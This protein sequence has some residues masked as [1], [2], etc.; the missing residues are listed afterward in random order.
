ML[1]IKRLAPVLL[2]AFLAIPFAKLPVWAGDNLVL[3]TSQAAQNAND[4]VSWAQLGGDATV[5]SSST[6]NANTLNGLTVTGTLAGPNSLTAVACPASPS[7]SWNSGFDGGDEVLW[8]ADAGNSG[9]GPLTVSFSQGVTGVGA[10]VQADAPGQ[11]TVQIQAFNQSG[12]LIHAPFT[13]LSDDHGDPTYIG[14]TDTFGANITAV[15]FSLV[16][17]CLGD[18]K[19]FATD[20]LYVNTVPASPTPTATATPTPTAIPTPAPTPAPLPAGPPTITL[21]PKSLAF[22]AV[23]YAFAGSGSKIKRLTITNPSKYKTAAI[24][25]S[26]V[27]TAGFSADPACNN[28][29]LAAGGKLKCNITYTPIGL[30]AVSGTLTINDNV[31]GGSQTVGVSGTGNQGKLTATPGTLSFGKITVNTSAAK[32]VTLRNRSAS[33]FTISSI[34]DANPAF[35][36]SQNCVGPIVAGG[37]CP[38]TVT[39][40]PTSTDKTTDT[41]SIIDAPDGITRNVNLTGSG[42]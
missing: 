26:I 6:F 38:I 4:S 7:C 29:T 17:P 41:L 35:V 16:Q 14:I 3:V 1:K 27:G 31:G 19:D 5:L 2:A 32:T 21:S 30:G 37:S 40:A 36:A 15:T 18:C 34:G 22:G 28:V 20:T 33:T 12:A 9:N 8:T 25:T 10:L 42:K 24:I 39:F 13:A 23:N 11:F